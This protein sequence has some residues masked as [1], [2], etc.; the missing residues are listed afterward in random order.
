VKL[1]KELFFV[2]LICCLGFSVK[3]SPAD[4]ADDVCGGD[5][6][7]TDDVVLEELGFIDFPKS[8]NPS[9]SA[10]QLFFSLI[11]KEPNRGRDSKTGSASP[12]F[13]T[14]A[15]PNSPTSSSDEQLQAVFCGDSDVTE[16]TEAVQSQYGVA[17]ILG[18]TTQELSGNFEKIQRILNQTLCLV[19]LPNTQESFDK[20]NFKTVF[21]LI[22]NH[23]KRIAP[24]MLQEFLNSKP[25]KCRKCCFCSFCEP[26]DNC[27]CFFTPRQIVD[28]KGLY[29]LQCKLKQI[30]DSDKIYD[31]VNTDKLNL[32]TFLA[33]RG[34]SPLLDEMIDRG[35]KMSRINGNSIL[36][37]IVASG[38]YKLLLNIL[39]TDSETIKRL[40]NELKKD[41]QGHTGLVVFTNEERG[42]FDSIQQQISVHDLSPD[43]TAIIEEIGTIYGF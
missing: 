39:N 1:S 5:F 10:E 42:A 18:L 4:A 11:E 6:I 26:D 14:P 43:V 36:R 37:K 25:P 34:S 41:V 9:G 3:V 19:I 21:L 30:L 38:D 24:Q 28:I 27:I 35:I 2:C 22:V 15:P 29:D 23:I 40:I 33:R 8:C 17:S 7:G 12:E 31:E 20:I 13:F 16:I 32:I